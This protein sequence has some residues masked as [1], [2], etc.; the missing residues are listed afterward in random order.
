[1]NESDYFTL[2]QDN[3][4]ECKNQTKSRESHIINLDDSTNDV[5]TMS[6]TKDKSEESKQIN[7]ITDEHH[8][9]DIDGII[10]IDSDNEQS[11]ATNNFNDSMSYPRGSSNLPR[12]FTRSGRKMQQ[13]AEHCHDK[14]ICKPNNIMKRNRMKNLISNFNMPAGSV[15]TPEPVNTKYMGSKECSICLELPKTSKSKP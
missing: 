5:K 12:K 9:N 1:M 4:S 7:L 11:K 6:I 10:E 14:D 3:L 8:S 13:H 15:V 2:K